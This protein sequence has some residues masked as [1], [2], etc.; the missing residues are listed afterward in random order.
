[1][2]AYYHQISLLAKAF[3]AFFLLL[4]ANGVFNCASVKEQL[5]KA[6]TWCG[7]VKHKL[8]L[9]AID[10]GGP[11]FKSLLNS[12]DPRLSAKYLLRYVKSLMYYARQHGDVE[13]ELHFHLD[14]PPEAQKEACRQYS[15]KSSIVIVRGRRYYVRSK[16]FDER[17][18][19][20]HNAIKKLNEQLQDPNS[21]LKK[22]NPLLKK[23]VVYQCPF[24]ADDG[25]AWFADK[26]HNPRAGIF[27]IPV[28]VDFDL[29]VKCPQCE[30]IINH[31]QYSTISTACENIRPGE[32]RF[33]FPQYL[34][35][36]FKE[37]YGSMSTEGFLLFNVAG[38]TD[39]FTGFG[40]GA[41]VLAQLL[42]KT[43]EQLGAPLEKNRLQFINKFLYNCIEAKKISV[44]ASERI[45]RIR[46]E[47]FT[48]LFYAIHYIYYDEETKMVR[49]EP[50]SMYKKLAEEIIAARNNKDG[51][52]PELWDA[53]R[54]FCLHPND[55]T[56]INFQFNVPRSS[57]SFFSNLSTIFSSSSKRSRSEDELDPDAAESSSSSSS[58]SRSLSRSEDE[59][60]ALLLTI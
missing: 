16:V 36:V 37:K 22:E 28:G 23:I 35:D 42:A 52:D 46:Q 12:D 17:N 3:T 57:S 56:R 19:I 41:E 8:Y 26:F 30:V 47:F 2:T 25:V 33:I 21:P 6:Y 58:P 27:V 11:A 14:G 24:Q 10:L 1:M 32:C 44:L 20:F 4:L 53:L 9:F 29:I 55:R 38:R 18:F 59:R 7:N 60:R 13:Y 45:F 15:N 43:E 39:D 31:L 49:C 48:G 5:S 34:R 51:T 40:F 50:H 54:G